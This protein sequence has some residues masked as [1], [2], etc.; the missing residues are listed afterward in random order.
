M[1][2][3]SEDEKRQVLAAWKA[4]GKGKAAFARQHGLSP[5]SLSRWQKALRPTGFVEVVVQGLWI[6]L[7]PLFGSRSGR[8]KLDSR[9]RRR[10]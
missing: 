3:R 5:N 2:R 7:T 1:A 10:R 9:W 8:T 6:R 4:S